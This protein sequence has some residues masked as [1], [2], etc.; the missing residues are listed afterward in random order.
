MP[1]L[2]EALLPAG[3]LGGGEQ[4]TLAAED[5]TLR[6][7]RP[8]D[9]DAIV[10]AYQDPGIQ[11]W[12]VRTVTETEA[13]QWIERTHVGW[14]AG[15]S[16]GWAVTCHGRL[17]GRVALR[18]IDR[19]DGVAEVSYWTLPESR[20]RAIAARALT[21]MTRWTLAAGVHRLELEHS[22]GND[23][24]CRVATKAGYLS[25]GTRRQAV[26][27]TDGWHDMHLHAALSATWTA[28]EFRDAAGGS[29]DMTTTSSRPVRE[30]GPDHPISV[31]PAAEHIVVT[32]AGQRIADSTSA[33][34]LQEADYP[35][36]YYIPRSDVAVDQLERTEHTTYCPYKG[37]ASYF[38]IPA[39]GAKSVNAIWTYEQPH[40]AVA[41]IKDHVAFYPDRVDDIRIG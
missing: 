29:A 27:H 4:P 5:L 15:S 9:A 20:G 33:L 18:T 3:P 36:V 2:T 28:P 26:R 11:R 6:A 8:E 40:Q 13:Q 30:P 24:S 1:E 23:A 32:V 19:W 14:R 17:V 10:A 7:W 34:R 38:S 39:G 25:E 16:A 31:T 12:H 22:T 37:D 41:E 35:A 21:A